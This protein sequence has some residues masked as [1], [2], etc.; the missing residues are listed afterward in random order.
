MLSMCKGFPSKP[1][2]LPDAR[3]RVAEWLAKRGLSRSDLSIDN[4]SGLSH[5]E[6]GRAM[7]MVQLLRQAWGAPYA[8][9]LLKSLP[10]AG[11]DGTLSARMKSSI[12][13]GKAFLKTGTLTD[14]RALAGYVQ[15]RSGKT[16]A[17]AAI[18][19]DPKAGKGV[20]A[21]DAFIA[22]IVDNG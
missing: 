20:A 7:A 15:A 12:A 11:E 6:K 16:Y 10:V 5:E 21:L 9:D 8:G 17:V 22:W 19:N 13:K 18:I 1:A 14:T 3:K 2:T 4:G